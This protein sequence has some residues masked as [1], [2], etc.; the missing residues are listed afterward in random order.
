MALQQNWEGLAKLSGICLVHFNQNS[1]ESGASCQTDDFCSTKSLVT[2]PGTAQEKSALQLPS[3]FP[4]LGPVSYPC[5]RKVK[6]AVG[7]SDF[8]KLLPSSNSVCCCSC[9]SC[10]CG[11]EGGASVGDP[12]AYFPN[13]FV[14]TD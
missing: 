11:A 1:S 10:V 6:E 8:L 3:H 5:S 14:V 7:S 13:Y 12:A 4:W 2:I 9:N